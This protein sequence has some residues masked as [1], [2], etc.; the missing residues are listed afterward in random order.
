M[1]F[2]S[3]KNIWIPKNDHNWS[4][5][6]NRIKNIV[7]YQPPNIPLHISMLVTTKSRSDAAACLF[8]TSPTPGVISS[9]P[10]SL[11][12]LP[13]TAQHNHL[14]INISKLNSNCNKTENI[15]T[16]QTLIVQLIKNK[17]ST[18]KEGRSFIYIYVWFPKPFLGDFPYYL[19]KCCY[20]Y[21]KTLVS[22]Q[23][24]GKEKGI[25]IRQFLT[26]VYG[27]TLV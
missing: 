25:V 17:K 13:K 2:V 12:L 1:L 5:A 23:C 26:F 16:I 6:I 8:S 10:L 4:A 7:Y 9:L 11:V 19:L 14:Q 18:G 21:H 22:L 15:F 20:G 24:Q 3:V 27:N